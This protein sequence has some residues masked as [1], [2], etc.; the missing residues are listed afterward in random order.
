M[1]SRRERRR[2]EGGGRAQPNAKSE[3]LLATYRGGKGSWAKE[4]KEEDVNEGR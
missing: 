1:K 2:S 4:K 3:D